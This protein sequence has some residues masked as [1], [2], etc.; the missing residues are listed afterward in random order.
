MEET[1]AEKVGYFIAGVGVV[2][3]SMIVSGFMPEWNVL[4]L[5]VWVAI[6]AVCCGLG[7]AVAHT[8]RIASFVGGA[9]AGGC[10]PFAL[11]GYVYVR[12]MLTETFLN[13]ELVIPGIIGALPGFGIYKLIS[14]AVD[15]DG[16]AGEDPL[17]SANQ[18]M[19]EE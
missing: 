16:E 8:P 9:V 18:D 4:P 19:E 15:P 17:L 3:P 5:A 2:L 12:V 1:P 11:I 6:S 7:M 14:S 10:I 13:I